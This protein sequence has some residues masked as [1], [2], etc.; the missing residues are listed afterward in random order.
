M[1]IESDYQASP[2]PKPMRYAYFIFSTLRIRSYPEW[3]AEGEPNPFLRL[4]RR[5]RQT[6]QQE[7]ADI[8]EMTSHEIA[9]FTKAQSARKAARKSRF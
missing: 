4:R 7:I 5:K 2:W 6:N 9:D 8:F 3:C 1:T